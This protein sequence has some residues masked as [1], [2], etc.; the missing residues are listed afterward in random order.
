MID[1]IVEKNC[2]GCNMCGDICPVNAI[3]YELDNEGFAFP[4]VNYDLC[5]KCKKC[6]DKCPVTTTDNLQK[7][8]PSVYAAWSKNDDVRIKSTSGGIY[9]ELAYSVI[10]EGGYICGAVYDADF[11]GAHHVLDNTMEGL[12]KI[13]GSKYFQSDARGI[14]KDIKELLEKEQMILFCGTPCQCAALQTFLGKDYQKLILVDFICRGINSPLAFRKHIEELEEQYGAPVKKVHLKNKKTGWQSLAT[15]VEFENGKSCHQDKNTSLWVKGFVGGGGG[16]Y[17][18]NSC[19]ECKYRTLPRISD[20][21]IGD[22]WGIQN[23]SHEDM[24]KGISSV[25]INSTKGEEV[26]S[27]IKD[28]IHVQQKNMDELEAGNL[29]IRVS[30][31][32]SN[33]RKQFF[34]I[35]EKKKFSEAVKECCA[36]KESSNKCLNLSRRILRKVLALIRLCRDISLFQFIKLNFFSKN[37]IR[38]KGKYIIPYKN[39]ILDLSKEA[40]IYVKGRHVRIGINKLKGSKAE[41]HVRMDGNAVWNSNNGCDLFHNTVLE[42]KSNAIFDTG[43]FSINGGS[44]IICAKHIKLGEDVMMGRNIIIYDS[45]H[46]EVWN[47]K[48]EK[49]NP[50]KDVVIEDHVWLTSNVTVLKGVTIG[51]DSLITAQTVIRKDVAKNSIVGG[52]ASGKVIGECNGWSRK[53]V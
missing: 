38:D 17:I 46:H 49:A 5:I 39:A 24:F 45:D 18:R 52:G 42:I 7:S 13:M 21:T 22:F 27:K 6:V 15:Y 33:E 50:S 11:K 41:T 2:T 26:F 51:R 53:S 25:M 37:V 30:P 8:R 4:I 19:Y 29:A 28:K 3:E 31:K 1:K 10:K 40:R 14:Y 48:L 16:L 44:V 9:Y 34:D 23:Q 20:I 35:L 32:L 47:E 36:E 12:N 43:Y